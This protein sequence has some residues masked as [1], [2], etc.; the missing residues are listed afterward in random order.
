M[1]SEEFFL[2]RDIF[3]TV[4]GKKGNV[5]KLYIAEMTEVWKKTN[6]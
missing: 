1:L 3:D 2:D 4:Y 6:L 5:H